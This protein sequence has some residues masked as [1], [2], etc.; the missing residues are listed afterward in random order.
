MQVS[1]E[2][3]QG[4]RKVY[5]IETM[6]SLRDLQYCTSPPEDLPEIIKIFAPKSQLTLSSSSIKN[7]KRRNNRRK[8]AASSN[9]PVAK[10]NNQ[11]EGLHAQV[12]AKDDSVL[13]C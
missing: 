2:Q 10:S 9:V 1:V 11:T 5:Q 4:A 6:C 3:N 12:M 7:K 13:S 8:R